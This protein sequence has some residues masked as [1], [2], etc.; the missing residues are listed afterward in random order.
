MQKHYLIPALIL[1]VLALSSSAHGQLVQIRNGYVKAP[2]VR[3]QKNADGSTYVRAPFVSVNGPPRHHHHAPFHAGHPHP[4]DLAR[5]FE[6]LQYPELC[7]SVCQTTQH[8]D[9]QLRSFPTGKYWQIHLATAELR[10]LLAA[11]AVR[12]EQLDH[13]VHEVLHT[14]DSVQQTPELSA[15]WQL[16]SFQ[17]IHIALRHIAAPPEV[18]IRQELSAATIELDESLSRLKNGEQWKNYLAT[19]FQA[20]HQPTPAEVQQ[21][22]QRYDSISDDDAIK[23]LPGF[24]HMRNTLAAYLECLEDHTTAEQVVAPEPIPQPAAAPDAS[25]NPADE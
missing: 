21:V 23:Q 13:R 12:T 3:V 17:S 24:Q 25:D 6:Q 2:F 8:L 18:R 9:A 20:D 14:Y 15:I 22:L 19:G 7:D 5:P 16:Y 10:Q 1:S 11:D 4:A